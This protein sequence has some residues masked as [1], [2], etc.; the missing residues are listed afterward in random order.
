MMSYDQLWLNEAARHFSL[1]RIAKYTKCEDITLE[2]VKPD[3][4]VFGHWMTLILI[5][6]QELRV[7]FKSHFFSSQIAA[8]IAK[9]IGEDK[10]T[11]TLPQTLDYM[12]EF[13]NVVGGGLKQELIENNLQV[14][15][16]LPILSRGIDEVFFPKPGGI[17]HGSDVWCLS[18]SELEVTCSVNYEIFDPNI[19]FSK[20][21]TD[22]ERS[23]TDGD[24]DFF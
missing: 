20:F 10:N 2:A 11:I 16:S 1:D 9:N 7:T 17:R 4:D 3:H 13:C 18:N 12:K 24:V 8:L 21:S 19:D 23:S 6:G 22:F 15:L 5:A 14:A